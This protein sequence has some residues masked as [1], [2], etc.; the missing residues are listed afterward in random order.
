MKADKFLLSLI[1][2]NIKVCFLFINEK[3]KFNLKNFDAFKKKVCL[4]IF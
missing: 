2:E 1:E 4:Y 3:K